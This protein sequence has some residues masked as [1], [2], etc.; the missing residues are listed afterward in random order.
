[1]YITCRVD[2][3][4][5]PKYTVLEEQRIKLRSKAVASVVNFRDG[6]KLSVQLGARGQVGLG[7]PVAS[8]AGP[9]I[10]GLMKRHMK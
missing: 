6:S 9:K 4:I 8:E 5:V 1:M 3:N 7:R 10:T 2:V